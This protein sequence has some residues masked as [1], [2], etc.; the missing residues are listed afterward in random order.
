MLPQIPKKY[1]SPSMIVGKRFLQYMRE[2]GDFPVQSPPETV[3]FLLQSS[4]YKFMQDTYPGI[5]IKGFGNLYLLELSQFHLGIC[6]NFGIGA[7]IVGILTE[8]L[9]AWGVQHFLILGTAG[10]LQSD[11]AIGEMILCDK[12]I[13]DEGTS[14][15]YLPAEKYAY[16]SPEL[17]ALCR[18]I[19]MGQNVL[20][21]QGGSWTI[22][23]P[24]RETACEIQQY[25]T[26][27]I[28][29]VEMEAAALFA[30]SRYL[31]LD[32][33]ALFVISDKFSD[34]GW[35][36]FFHAV[37]LP[38]QTLCHAVIKGISSEERNKYL[39]QKR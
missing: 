16:A 3:I 32:A 5:N 25:R 9:A 24:Y 29:T 6:G 18:E 10:G 35:N 14:F 26:E 17:V 15:H 34:E 1:N 38:L 8:E 33:A 21:R 11:L 36:P 28:L 23:T 22:D 20:F 37:D 4:L 2:Q 12:A 39:T 31:G 30:V 27:G 19:L 13:R 7:P